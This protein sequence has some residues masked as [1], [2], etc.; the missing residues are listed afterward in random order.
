MRRWFIISWSWFALAF[1][2]CGGEEDSLSF[3]EGAEPPDAGSPAVEEPTT[4]PPTAD[5]DD[6]QSEPLLTCEEAVQQ[7]ATT[8]VLEGL[9]A[10]QASGFNLDDVLSIAEGSVVTPTTIGATDLATTPQQVV[11]ACETCL[12]DAEQTVVEALLQSCTETQDDACAPTE[13]ELASCRGA[14][15]QLAPSCEFASMQPSLGGLLA[16]Q[17][18]CEDFDLACPL[19][20][21]ALLQTL[22]LL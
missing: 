15:L 4:S 13:S 10:L 20:S 22:D 21:Q 1:T 16:T 11:A 8:N 7:L 5:P 19:I 6:T 9:C 14:L 12:A 18:G 17:A 2:G 3:A